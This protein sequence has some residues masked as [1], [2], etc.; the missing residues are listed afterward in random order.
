MLARTTWLIGSAALLLTVAGSGAGAQTVGLPPN[1]ASGNCYPFG[2]D[3][4]PTRYQQV[5]TSSVFTGPT[6][7]GTLTF[8]HTV[9]AA[10]AGTFRPATY[11]I[12]LSTTSA[13]VN[14]LSTNLGANVTGP[15]QLLGTFSLSGSVSGPSFS[16]TGSNAFL[17]NPSA[18]N[19]L[20]DV[21]VTGNGRQSGD[22]TYFDENATGTQTSRAYTGATESGSASDAADHT[23][24]V[25]TFSP[26]T[27]TTTPEPSSVALLG[28]GLVG[29]VPMVRRQLKA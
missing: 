20:M 28:T 7:I 29:L 16:F 11:S 21:F 17:Y 15:E 18:G 8:Y 6:S 23:G 9:N 22:Y 14:G 25:T 1:T 13:S 5:Y 4:G 10:F 3:Y 27:A 24:L 19:L 26:G 12:F 2:C